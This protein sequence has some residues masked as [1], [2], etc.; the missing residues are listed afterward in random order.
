LLSKGCF[1]KNT[2]SQVKLKNTCHPTLK[3]LFESLTILD[4]CAF[5]LVLLKI[6]C[7][8]DSVYNKKCNWKSHLKSRVNSSSNKCPHIMQR[9]LVS[10]QKQ[11]KTFSPERAEMKIACYSFFCHKSLVVKM[12]CFLVLD[13]SI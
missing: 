9:R 5:N 10:K 2:K 6:I 7:L 3:R 13:H 1:R 11:K 8:G 12:T 4:Y